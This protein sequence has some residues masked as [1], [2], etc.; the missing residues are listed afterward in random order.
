MTDKQAQSYESRIYQG[1]EAIGQKVGAAYAAG[2]YAEMRRQQ[3]AAKV[4]MFGVRNAELLDIATFFYRK[5]T[6]AGR[7]VVATES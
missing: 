7:G 4:F 6:D 3:R 5:G 1:I 2:D